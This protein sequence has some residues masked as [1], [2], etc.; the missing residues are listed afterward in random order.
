[1]SP[2]RQQLPEEGDEGRGLWGKKSRDA[3]GVEAGGC[4]DNG[5]GGGTD[6]GSGERKNAN[7]TTIP[8]APQLAP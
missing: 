6:S 3:V 7:R 1:M 5:S 4:A 8:D 2:A